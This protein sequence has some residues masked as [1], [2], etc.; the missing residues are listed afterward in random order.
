[1]PNAPIALF[2]YNRPDHTRRTVDALKQNGLAQESD[3][4]IFSDAPK[5]EAH[6]KAV[7]DV[8]QFVRKIVGFKSVRVVERDSNFGLARSVINGVTSVINEYGRIIVMEDDLTVSPYFLEFMNTALDTYK[9]ENEVMHISAYMFPI[10][11]LDL[12]ETL[13][14]RGASCWGWATW[15]RAWDFFETDTKK[16]LDEI[17]IKKSE[18]EF[19]IQGTVGYTKM[20]EN[21][22]NGNIDSWAVRWYA[23]VF[24]NGGNCLHPSK[25]LVNNTGHD[26]SGIHCGRSSIYDVEILN[27]KPTINSQEIK[28]NPEG[29]KAIK[30]FYNSL[31]PPFYIRMYKKIINIIKVW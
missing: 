9:N 25:S 13:F 14:F 24:L 12:P 11:D 5:S 19:D 16:L 17:R 22:L 28:E 23:S 7:N 1:M 6:F 4:I 8:R 18:Y 30:Q 15:A 2:V 10:G 26:G 3:L 20:L 21:Q 31:K 29:L 27:I